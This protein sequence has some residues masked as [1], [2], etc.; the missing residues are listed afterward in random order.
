MASWQRTHT[1]GELTASAI[2]RT[3]T[4]NGWIE[5]HR[6]HGQILFVDL[7]DRYGVTQ[8]VVDEQRGSTAGLLERTIRLGAEDVLSVTGTVQPRGEGNVNPNRKTGAIEVVATDVVVLNEAEPPPIEVLDDVEASE[9]LRM[10]WRYLDL[11]RRPM[12]RALELRA[13][14]VTSVRNYLASHQFVDV[15]TPILTKSTPEGARDYL[16]PSRVHAGKFYALPQSP[17]IFKQ[18][19]M[20]GGLD[21]YYQIARCFR[22]EDLRAD[23]QPEFTQI[24]IEMSFVEEKDVLDIVEGMVVQSFREGFGV[25]LVTPFPRLDYFDAIQRFGSDKPDLRF[26]IELKDVTT[27]VASSGFKVFADTVAA[28]GVV[29]GLCVPN[30]DKFSRKDIDALTAFVGGHGAKGLGW[31]KVTPEGLTGSIAKFYAGEAGA[32]LT[33]AMG[34][35]LGDLLLFV[36]DKPKVV[37]KALGELRLKVG[38]MLGLRDPKQFRFAWV[39]N[40]PMFEWNEDKQRFD[41]AHHPFTAPVDWNIQD[42]G[43]DTERIRSRAYDIVMNGWELGSGSIRIH[44]P[45]LQARVFQFLGIGP[46]EQRAKFGFLLDAFRHGAPPHGGI[47][48]GVDRTVTLALG[49]ESIRDVI[50]FPKTASAT[51]LMCEAPSEVAADQLAELHVATLRK[52]P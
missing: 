23:R 43:V 42:F 14:F 22:D 44:R 30:A 52:A 19:L 16:V 13:K 47:A 39:L 6:H 10:K 36:A 26:G 5:N 28:G 2:G 31:A 38:S 46:E 45:D 3:V 4:L 20:V 21:R 29:K 11:R 33:T 35:K 12:T 8:V 18:L 24:D 32:E 1:C 50:A 25:D 40:F 15:E 17:Q 51:D 48:L 9:E 7:R 34:G 41:S 27:V 49:A 37:H